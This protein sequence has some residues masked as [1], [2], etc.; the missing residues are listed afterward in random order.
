MHNEKEPGVWE[1]KYSTSL[2]NSK[3]L[4][5]LT[6]EEIAH[7]NVNRQWDEGGC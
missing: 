7:R 4:Y 1:D 5:Y 6:K 3:K 2:L